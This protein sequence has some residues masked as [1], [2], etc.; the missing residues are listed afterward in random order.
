MLSL[1]SGTICEGAART[2]AWDEAL[3]WAP[4][5]TKLGPC[6]LENRMAQALA[7][8]STVAL[9]VS[10]IVMM[11]L[12]CG[13]PASATPLG[14]ADLSSPAPLVE[15]AQ[16]YKR[17][18]TPIYPYYFRPGPPGGWDFYFGFVPYAK[19]DIENQAVQRQFY[20]QDSW[21]HN[22]TYDPYAGGP[23]PPPRRRY[24]RR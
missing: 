24:Y 8:R 23:P 19:G 6:L 18:R 1:E 22:L 12:S 15:P 3:R 10:A 21:P 7:F 16:I 5:V 13:E 11:V 2:T 14:P 20:P 17:G 9:A 4:A